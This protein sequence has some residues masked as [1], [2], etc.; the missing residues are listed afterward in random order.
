M[1]VVG[2]SSL[3]KDRELELEQ[4][5]AITAPLKQIAEVIGVDSC[6]LMEFIDGYPA[7]APIPGGAV[8][9]EERICTARRAAKRSPW[10]SLG[11]AV[12]ASPTHMGVAGDGS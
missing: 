1:V 2:I 12:V 11:N 10:V 8:D 4:G 5:A 3:V 6:R 7:P 9:T